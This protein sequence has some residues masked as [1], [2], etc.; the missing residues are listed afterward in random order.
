MP[1]FKVTRQSPVH[2][3][4]TKAKITLLFSDV[5]TAFFGL[6]QWVFSLSESV[7]T[8]PFTGNHPFSKWLTNRAKTAHNKK[9]IYEK[10]LK[11][12]GF[13]RR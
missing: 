1:R 12:E 10:S 3:V 4:V 13:H 8:S 9:D 11:R 7:G 6:F 2:S 5:K